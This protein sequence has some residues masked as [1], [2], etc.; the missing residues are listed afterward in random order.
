MRSY[1]LGTPNN[2][3]SK[4]S[5][6]TGCI[7]LADN[8][9]RRK[10]EDFEFKYV[11]DSQPIDTSERNDTNESKISSDDQFNS[12]V[13][14]LKIS[15]VS[16]LKGKAS[17]DLFNELLETNESDVNQMRLLLARMRALD[18]DSRRSQHL[19]RQ[20]CLANKVLDLCKIHDLMASHV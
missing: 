7:K 3:V 19:Y 5:Y 15:W 17:E 1:P 6:F 4:G 2:N 13:N 16:I 8:Y 20:I 12:A 14:D 10:A 18:S 9:T 11:I